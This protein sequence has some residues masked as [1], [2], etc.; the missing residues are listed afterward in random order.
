MN[1][2]T[3]NFALKVRNI[4]EVLIKVTMNSSLLG[5]DAA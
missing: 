3:Q 4:V 2:E 5:C 1:E